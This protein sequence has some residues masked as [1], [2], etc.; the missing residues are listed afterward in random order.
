MVKIVENFL[1][2][3]K[4]NKCKKNDKTYEFG[5]RDSYCISDSFPHFEPIENRELRCND[6]LEEIEKRIQE[7]KDKRNSL[8]KNWWIKT[9]YNGIIKRL[10]KE[11]LINK[12]E[13]KILKRI[14]Y[15]GERGCLEYLWGCI[16][17]Y[18]DKMEAKRWK[19]V[20][21]ALLKFKSLRYKEEEYKLINKKKELCRL[22]ECYK[23]K[24]KSKP[25]KVLL[26]TCESCGVETPITGKY[27]QNCGKEV[28]F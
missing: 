26:Q 15:Y 22:T 1:R 23:D 16:D 18:F 28:K 19:V 12:K 5:C 6:C 24:K 2:Y 21:K 7:E 4:C 11:K 9:G 25:T 20:E 13:F 10:K 14:W 3:E 27:C 8:A 17:V